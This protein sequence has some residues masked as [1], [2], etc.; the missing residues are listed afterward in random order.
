[1]VV[2]F[3]TKQFAIDFHN[4]KYIP[5]LLDPNAD[6]KALDNALTAEGCARIDAASGVWVIGPGTTK[7]SL[8]K[9]PPHMP[10]MLQAARLGNA[11]I[12]KQLATKYG[13]EVNQRRRD[14]DNKVTDRGTALHLAAY[15]GHAE[16]VNTLLELNSDHTN[17][18]KYSE[19]A[20]ESAKKG[21]AAYEK[22]KEDFILNTIGNMLKDM[23]IRVDFTTLEGWRGWDEI[24][25]ELEKKSVDKTQ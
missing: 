20:L 12:V 7:F 8:S 4:K 24:K 15:F 3:D 21:K 14:S 10:F 6:E 17:K 18:N 16:V 22:D 5:L 25:I 19:T 11:K 23:G 9:W 1:V 2:Q 13:C